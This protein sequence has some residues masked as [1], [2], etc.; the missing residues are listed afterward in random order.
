MPAL[1]RAPI[2]IVLASNC[3]AG[4][5]AW[6]E[7]SRMRLDHVILPAS[8]LADSIAFYAALGMQLIV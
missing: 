4:E 7:E 5:P 2:P 8:V 1:T 6:F 3:A